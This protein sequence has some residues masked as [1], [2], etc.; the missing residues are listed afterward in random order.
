[1]LFERAQRWVLGI[2]TCFTLR[3]R[4]THL[5]DMHSHGIGAGIVAGHVVDVEEWVLGIRESHHGTADVRVAI[6]HSLRKM[7]IF[8]PGKQIG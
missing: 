4:F 2:R 6:D 1:M 3:G 5:V 8:I 7:T